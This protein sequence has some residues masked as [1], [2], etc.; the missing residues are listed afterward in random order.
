MQQDELI[1]PLERSLCKHCSHRVTREISTE[2]FI[3]TDDDGDACDDLDSFIH[4]ACAVLGIDL[5]H[6]VL[7]CNKFLLTKDTYNGN[8][9][10]IRDND[11]LNKVN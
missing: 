10:F 8:K 11:I 1:H 2:G 7:E 6:I 4:D 9:N 3:L 5:D